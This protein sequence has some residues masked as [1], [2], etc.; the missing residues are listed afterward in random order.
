MT[1]QRTLAA[2]QA[3]GVPWVTKVHTHLFENVLSFVKQGMGVALL[4]PFTVGFK[5]DAGITI[6]PFLP[7]IFIDVAVIR[8]RHRPLSLVGKAFYEQLNSEISAYESNSLTNPT[9]S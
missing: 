3:A 2:F 5:K 8:S 9:S 7:S 1:Y 4:D 6:R